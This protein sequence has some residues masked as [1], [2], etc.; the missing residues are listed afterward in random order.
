MSLFTYLTLRYLFRPYLLRYAVHPRVRLSCT[1]YCPPFFSTKSEPFMVI[2]SDR[3]AATARTSRREYLAE[4]WPIGL[5]NTCL[6]LVFPP[7][8][9]F[10]VQCCLPC[11]ST[12]LAG[13]IPLYRLTCLCAVVDREGANTFHPQTSGVRLLSCCAVGL[14]SSLVLC[15]GKVG[16]LVVVLLRE[17]LLKLI[18]SFI[19]ETSFFGIFGTCKRLTN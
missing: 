5:S 9:V 16:A 6:A 7:V 1:Y 12:D 4:S 13:L 3:C 18:C 2:L 14:S 19:F 8:I 17:R 11:S 10:T 15:R